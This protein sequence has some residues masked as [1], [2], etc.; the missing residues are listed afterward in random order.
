[1]SFFI[2][3]NIKDIVNE[4]DISL[5]RDDEKSVDFPLYLLIDEYKIEVLHVKGTEVKIIIDQ[6]G[7]H[8][9]NLKDKNVILKVFGERFKEFNSDQIEI[10]SIEKLSDTLASA[11]IFIYE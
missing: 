6:K 9:L 2:S 10:R 5:L 7:Y 1:M 8:T 3:S 11:L 4:S